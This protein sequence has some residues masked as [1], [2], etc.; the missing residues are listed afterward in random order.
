MFETRYR[1]LVDF[2]SATFT[3]PNPDFNFK[4]LRGN[5]VLRWE[6]RPGSMLYFVWTQRRSDPSNPG[7]FDL[8]RDLGDVFR[9]PG[10]N[11]FLVK[12]SYRFAL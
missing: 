2:D 7:E 10:D 9:A 5:A 11:V 1:N 3:P 4:S 6:Y 8:W 12:F